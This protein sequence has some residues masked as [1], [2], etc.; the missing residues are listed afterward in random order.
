MGKE[1]AHYLRPKCLILQIGKLRSREG[2]ASLKVI[3]QME[4]QIV[5]GTQHCVPWGAVPAKGHGPRY[6]VG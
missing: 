2:S 6:A 4:G 1:R 5:G 3:Q